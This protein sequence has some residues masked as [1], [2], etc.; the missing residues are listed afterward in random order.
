M[1]RK[2]LIYILKAS[3]APV[4]IATALWAKGEA[5]PTHWALLALGVEALWQGV[6][7]WGAYLSEPNG[8][9]SANGHTSNLNPE[10]NPTPK[11][12]L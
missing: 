12:E 8:K 1:N 10:T 7:A 3:L 6:N 2:C 11:T 9:S 4:V 5:E